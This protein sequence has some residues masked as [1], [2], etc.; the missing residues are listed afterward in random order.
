MARILAVGLVVVCALVIALAACGGD[1]DDGGGVTETPA[2]TGPVIFTSEAFSSGGAI[3]LEYSCDG[4]NISPPLTWSRLP[5][6]TESLVLTIDD[7]DAD[8][9]VH[10]VVYDLP[11]DSVG[12]DANVPPEGELADGSRQGTNSRGETG[13]TGPCPPGG[14]HEYVF[15][16]YALDAETGLEA[17]ASLAEVEAA[18]ADHVLALSELVGTYSR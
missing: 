8:R 9:F 12:L 6:G 15:R 4:D 14:E 1:D 3:P 5:A 13:Y 11:P 10:W 17:G 18:I 2:A 16:I 7:P